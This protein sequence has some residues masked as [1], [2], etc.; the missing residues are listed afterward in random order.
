MTNYKDMY[1]HLAGKMTTAIET[2]DNLSQELKETQQ[3]GEAVF[4]NNCEVEE[5]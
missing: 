3:L 5:C 2:L 4:V 1:F